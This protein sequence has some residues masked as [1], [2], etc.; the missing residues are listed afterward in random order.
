M[1]K[2]H[3]SLSRFVDPV[4]FQSGRIGADEEIDDTKG[5]T[6]EEVEEM[7]EERELKAGTQ[8]LEMVCV[9][10]TQWRITKAFPTGIPMLIL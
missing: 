4:S 1:L 3:H 10:K 5:K 8:I 2:E 7:A 9:E 6:M